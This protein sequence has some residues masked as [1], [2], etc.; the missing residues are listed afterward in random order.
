MYFESRG[1]GWVSLF[2]ASNPDLVEHQV[3][4]FETFL[5]EG[6][7]IAQGA[8]SCFH[9]GGELGDILLG[10][11]QELGT[12]QWRGAECLNCFGQACALGGSVCDWGSANEARGRGG[13][14]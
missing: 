12:S 9:V 5:V 4:V 3:Q 14:G 6:V 8:V 7:H 11:E 13:N 2:S 10:S 1:E